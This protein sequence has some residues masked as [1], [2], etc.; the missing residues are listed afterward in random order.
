MIQILLVIHIFIAALLVGVILIQ[1]SEGGGLGSAQQASLFTS[2]GSANFFTRATATLAII[3][4]VSCLIMG[5]LLGKKPEGVFTKP[6]VSPI[7]DIP[8]SPEK[9]V[10]P[11]Q[12]NIAPPT[13]EAKKP[14]VKTPQPKQ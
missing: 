1:K 7:I 13:P 6:V 12:I 9:P 8:A 11:S 3:F 14:E 4:A 10:V 5:I 2:R